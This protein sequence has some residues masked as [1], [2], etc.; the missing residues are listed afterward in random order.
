MA[1]S[2]LNWFKHVLRGVVLFLPLVAGYGFLFPWPAGEAALG[3]YAGQTPVMIAASYRA[4]TSTNLR[5][6]TSVTRTEQMRSYL[7]LPSVLTDPKVV[8]VWQ[9][10]EE[11]PEVSESRIPL[12]VFGL[13]A[14]AALGVFAADHL[15]R[16]ERGPDPLSA[17]QAK[18]IYGTTPPRA[19]FGTRKAPA[20][21]Q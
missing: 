7:L 1:D 19:E 13:L 21:T 14:I 18:A 17:E 6:Q 10:N 9:T 8:T 5:T 15:R 16:R 11:P 12:V 3:V 2:F 20:A 4:K